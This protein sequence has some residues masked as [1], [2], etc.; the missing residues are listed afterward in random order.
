MLSQSIVASAKAS[1]APSSSRFAA[2][3]PSAA[4]KVAK[5]AAPVASSNN[6]AKTTLANL[7]DAKIEDLLIN[8][9]GK[10]KVI[11]MLNAEKA[12]RL[13]EMDLLAMS[14]QGNEEESE[15]ADNELS[16]RIETGLIE[17]EA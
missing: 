6:N 13:S 8:N 11:K 7:S 14:E 4:K 17:M 15:A 2:A 1:A 12:R 3:A 5:A 10:D 16:R 9:A